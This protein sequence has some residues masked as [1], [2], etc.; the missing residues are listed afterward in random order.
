MARW[1]PPR[2]KSSPHI[3]PEGFHCLEQELRGLWDK[4]KSVVIALSDAAA[5]G[6]RSENAECAKEPQVMYYIAVTY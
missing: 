6:D 4:R 3:T 1:K 2:P 5:E